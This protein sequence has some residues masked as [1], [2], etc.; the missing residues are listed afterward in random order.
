MPEVVEIE[1]TN[2]DD[3][4]KIEPKWNSWTIEVPAEIVAAQGLTEGTIVTLT[5][6]N[7]EVDAT[8]VQPTPDIKQFVER[9]AEENKE[10]LEEM[11]RLGD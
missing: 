2:V 3:V 7:G 1:Q 11:K 4:M 9:F 5:I 10:F 6:R 8:I